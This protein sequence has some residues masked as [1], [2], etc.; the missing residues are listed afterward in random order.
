MTCQIEDL[1]EDIRAGI[2]VN[3]V[4]GCWEWTPGGTAGGYGYIYRDGSQQLVHRLVYS[5]LV[6]QIP[7]G[8]TIDHVKDR[9]CRSKACCW[10][11]HL[12]AVVR[13][14]NSRRNAQDIGRRRAAAGAV[15]AAGANTRVVWADEARRNL[16]NLLD[17][18]ARGYHITILRYDK[19]AAVLVPVEWYEQ[20]RSDITGS[21]T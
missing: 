13:G 12:E 6:E 4:S 8:L 5:L 18:V 9:G 2:V 7:E 3:P 21:T 14:E 16:R 11:P 1:P 10:P 15:L 19:P 17:E 20:A